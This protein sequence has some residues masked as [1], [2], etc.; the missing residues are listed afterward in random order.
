[1]PRVFF[2][3]HLASHGIAALV[4]YDKRGVG[5]SI[6]NWMQS[7]F[8]DLAD[9]AVAGIT[10]LKQH[11][12]IDPHRIGIYGHSQGGAIAPLVGVSF[13]RCGV[14]HRRSRRRRSNV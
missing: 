3:E 6:G 14:R 2:A 7:D 12:E 1:M 9:D 8:I 11:K 4:I 5:K 13:T 10:L